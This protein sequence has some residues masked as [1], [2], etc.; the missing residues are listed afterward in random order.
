M[1]EIRLACVVS[2]P[3]RSRDPTSQHAAMHSFGPF[4]LLVLTT[5]CATSGARRSRSSPAKPFTMMIGAGKPVEA[6]AN[7]KHLANV[8]MLTMDN[9]EAY[10]ATTAPS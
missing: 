5:A 2:A 7:E 4:T 9:A 3:L 1:G 10:G 6:L 8:R